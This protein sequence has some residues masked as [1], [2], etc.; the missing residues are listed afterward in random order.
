MTLHTYGR[1]FEH[2]II[3]FLFG[4]T[5]AILFESE[6]QLRK[7]ASYKQLQLFFVLTIFMAA[8]G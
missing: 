7:F 2:V 1:T 8:T 4:P 6:M 3:K 5:F